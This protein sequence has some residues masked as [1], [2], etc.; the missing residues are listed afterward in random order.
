MDAALGGVCRK[1]GNTVEVITRQKEMLS[2]H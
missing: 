2:T 1:I